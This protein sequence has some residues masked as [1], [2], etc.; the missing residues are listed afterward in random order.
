MNISWLVVA[1]AFCMIMYKIN[2]S[3]DKRKSCIIIAGSPTIKNKER[4]L[5]KYDIVIKMNDFPIDES[6]NKYV[7][8]RIDIW[9]V[10]GWT[11]LRKVTTDERLK[12]M[13]NNSQEIWIKNS[14][15]KLKKWI[16]RI[17]CKK[18]IVIDETEKIKK[19]YNMEKNPSLGFVTIVKALQRF[20]NVTLLGFTFSNDDKPHFYNDDKRMNNSHNHAQEGIII[21]ELALSSK[22]IFF[23]S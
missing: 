2:Q 1:L 12:Y 16:Q 11:G 6:L 21:K 17:P 19:R 10:N 8:D 14:G 22:R 13:C 4:D 7:S 9:S 5:S 20:K 15:T 18:Y 23:L 3:K